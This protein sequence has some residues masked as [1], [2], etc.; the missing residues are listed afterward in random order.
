MKQKSKA[1]WHKMKTY[2]YQICYSPE[3]LENIPEGFKVLDN[4]KNE[5]PDWREFWAIRQFLKSNYLA[6]DALYGFMSPK[7]PEKTGLNYGNIEKF[8][9]DRYEGEDIVSFSPFWDLI[10]IFKNIF[11]QGDF[12]HAGLADACQ[13]F[14]NK[15][16]AGI[17]L[18][19][20]IT[21][22]QNSI[23]CN[24]FLAKKSFW[25]QWLEVGEL[26]FSECENN[27]SYLAN[28]LNDPTTYG[29]Q[30]LPMKIFVQERLATMLLL[31]NSD[32]KCLSYSP[33]NIGASRTFFNKFLKQA[34]L[35]DALKIAYSKTKNH[36]YLNEF[37]EIRNDLI[38]SINAISNITDFK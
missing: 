2:I 30:H 21:H 25:N 6:D 16:L 26:L 29:E 17:D 13:A 24:Y 22:S 31:A 36:G 18:I 32:I 35:G 1:S 33:F 8:I 12:F 38:K 27:S 7:F 5:R 4:L 28:I 14:S 11:E 19:D 15:H 20:S 37:S 23:F 34:L 9:H 3:T 10:G